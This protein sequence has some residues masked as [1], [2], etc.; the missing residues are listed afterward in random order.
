MKWLKVDE[1][2]NWIFFVSS[3]CKLLYVALFCNHVVSPVSSMFDTVRL[4][5]AV[6]SKITL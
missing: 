4:S 1:N 2:M 3:V 5:A 6:P